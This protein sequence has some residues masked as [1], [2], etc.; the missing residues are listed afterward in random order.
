M[1]RPHVSSLRKEAASDGIL[2]AT[3]S[4]AA[5][6]L[7]PAPHML[8]CKVAELAPSRQESIFAGPQLARQSV[9][10][11]VLSWRCRQVLPPIFS[12]RSW[13]K[14]WGGRH[15]PFGKPVELSG[16]IACINFKGLLD[17]DRKHLM[18]GRRLEPALPD[19]SEVTAPG[20]GTLHY[21]F[22]HSIF[23]IAGRGTV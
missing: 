23:D 19:G 16:E 17:L 7:L 9:S 8:F 15:R 5:P 6:I 20:K 11:C 3:R 1:T 13:V 10:P 12:C 2:A 4:A 21:Y 18:N 14:D 22:Y